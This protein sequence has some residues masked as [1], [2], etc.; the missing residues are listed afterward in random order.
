MEL[1]SVVNMSHKYR[2][3]GNKVRNIERKL[4]SKKQENTIIMRTIRNT[5]NA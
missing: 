3:L 1:Y 2:K 4:D 5:P